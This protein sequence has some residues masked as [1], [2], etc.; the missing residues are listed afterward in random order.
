VTAI[1]THCFA[2]HFCSFFTR[3]KGF[4]PYHPPSRNSAE[5][6]KNSAEKKKKETVAPSF[7]E[8]YVKA[9]KEI[10]EDDD[11]TLAE[12]SVLRDPTQ[13]HIYIM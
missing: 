1:I 5:R 11:S 13:M 7:F 12:R 9:I 2:T 10:Q 8:E 4:V 3:N 6:K